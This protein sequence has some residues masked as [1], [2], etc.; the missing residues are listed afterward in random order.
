MI[1]VFISY[2]KLFHLLLDKDIKDGEFRR[3][4]DISAPTLSKLKSNKI[5][6]TEVILKICKA[7]NCQPSDIMEYVDDDNNK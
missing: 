3:M 5:V 2:K 7:L 1:F 6:T 4:V